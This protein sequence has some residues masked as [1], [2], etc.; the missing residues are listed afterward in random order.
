MMLPTLRLLSIAAVGILLS[1]VSGFQSE[2]R[3][4]VIRVDADT[5]AVE[6]VTR[7]AD[8]V[9]GDLRLPEDGTSLHYVLHLRPDG[10]TGLANVA[11]ESPGFFTGTIL[12]GTPSG[13]LGQAGVAGRVVRAPADYLPVIGVSMGLI[14]YVLRLHAR[15]TSAAVVVK[16]F[17]IRNGLPGRLTITHLAHDSVLVDCQACQRARLTEELRIGL[18]RDGGIEGGV[19]TEQR[20]TIARR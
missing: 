11:D 14:D 9:T 20:W 1:G 8:S 16:V 5:L 2:T 15:D 3:T 4:F 12:F 7:S 10:T 13:Y 18:A 17:N 6:H 19:R